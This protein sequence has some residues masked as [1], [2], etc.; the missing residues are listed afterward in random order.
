MCKTL[1][2]KSQKRKSN[3]WKMCCTLKVKVK[4]QK[5]AQLKM[6]RLQEE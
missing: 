6:D 1:K 5:G 2:V 4:S 3:A